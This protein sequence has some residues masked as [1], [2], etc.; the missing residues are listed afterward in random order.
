MFASN[1]SPRGFSAEWSSST[2][3]QMLYWK[4]VNTSTSSTDSIRQP[5]NKLSQYKK[6][7]RLQRFMHMEQHDATEE[8][9]T[10]ECQIV[11]RDPETQKETVIFIQNDFADVVDCGAEFTLS[12]DGK[13]LSV[14]QKGTAEKVFRHSIMAK[15]LI[16]DIQAKKF[17]DVS[18]NPQ[19]K[20]KALL[21]CPTG[22][23]LAFV[24]NNNL[25]VKQLPAGTVVPVT[26][27][28]DNELVFNGVTDWIYE[29]EVFGGVESFVWNND[30][31]QV[32][33]LRLDDTQVNVYRYEEYDAD[34]PY[35]IPVNIRIP[36]P[37]Y[38]NPTPSVHVYSVAANKVKNIDLGP[39]NTGDISKD[40]Y[41]YDLKWANN[42]HLAVVTV[43]RVQQKKNIVLANTAEAA[44]TIKP[45]LIRTEV[46]D[47]WIQYAR[48][49][50]FLSDIEFVDLVAFNDSYHIALFVVGNNEP[51]KYLTSG[52]YEV[53]EIYPVF[54]TAT[55]EIYY[56]STERD[57]T[58]RHVYAVNTVT[59]A[60]RALS[61]D[62][63]E[64]YYSASFSADGQYYILNYQGPN[65]P[66]TVLK[67]TDTTKNITQVLSD[68]S[69]L[70]KT[71]EGFAM[72]HTEITT[73]KNE[74]GD[75]MNVMFVYPSDWTKGT[76]VQYPV[77]FY[78][79]NG[80]GS[81][82][83]TKSWTATH[84]SF[85]LYMA[86]QGFI[87]VTI[88]GRGT[89]FKGIRYM[90]ETYENLGK[91]EVADQIYAAK[92]IAKRAD[93][94]GERMAIWGW[95]YGGYM[96]SKTI[97]ST[98]N[99]EHTFK[100]G[101]SVAPVTDWRYYD[102]AYTERYMQ[103]PAV[104]QV[105]YHNSSVITQVRDSEC[106]VLPST[107]TN[108]NGETTLT[109]STTRFVIVH[110]TGDDNVHPLNS[111]NLMTE[112]QQRQV[113]FETMF[114]PNKDHSITGGN[115]RKQL[116]RFLANRLQQHIIDQCVV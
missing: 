78:L 21:W 68:N 104:N 100:L 109:Q 79:Y 35:P 5:T 59:G 114:Y 25:F 47:T 27:D 17:S 22:T 24:E 48:D 31:S 73:I 99:S 91:L 13:Y 74:K 16:Y 111:Y 28:G 14:Q 62:Q 113:Q 75:D 4:T 88:D 58:E 7:N 53:T 15:Y 60:K 26:N 10:L 29:E 69:D 97:T 93:T 92:Q 55:N 85:S 9:N 63:H 90:T 115:T 84:N 72:P 36:T 94:D 34:S 61:D 42:S 71:L 11:T 44:D 2:S 49:V 107:S 76:E 106:P 64:G 103:W 96:S 8:E 77:L 95:S 56:V 1:L 46:I 40:F 51:V 39:V 70:K 116:Y 33:W 54:N 105:G 66:Y 98:L 110:G 65:L 19:N 89:G 23:A 112:L 20:Q 43:P 67:T 37:G 86:A 30:C 41:V 6:M 3:N 81:Q 57:S 101:I 18:T 12:A 87:V 38:A 82:L 102:S 83:V 108:A 45:T 52:P 50:V 80:P 32:A